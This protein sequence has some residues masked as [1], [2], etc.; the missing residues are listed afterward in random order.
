MEAKD[1]KSIHA[2]TDAERQVL[3]SRRP[4]PEA[5]AAMEIG[6]DTA[7]RRV[8]R[9]GGRLLAILAVL[10][11]FVALFFR[12]T[13]SW[14]VALIVVGLMGAYMLVIGRMVEGRADRLD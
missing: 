2:M 14:R 7:F 3:M 13:A 12:F 8:I 9:A 11:I 6:G 4:A 5:K 10:A 1:P